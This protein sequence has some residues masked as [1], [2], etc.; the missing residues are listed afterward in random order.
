MRKWNPAFPLVSKNDLASLYST[1]VENS[2]DLLPYLEE[3]RMHLDIGTGGG[4]P[5]I[6][7]AIARPDLNVVV[8]DRSRNKCRFLRHVKFQLKLDNVEVWEEHIGP[9][10]GYS[11]QFDTISVRAVAPPRR[12]WQLGRNLLNPT[13]SVLLHTSSELKAEHVSD[14]RVL[15]S[16]SVSRGWVSAVG[17]LQ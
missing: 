8:N 11:E 14:A 6:S 10:S 9:N 7:L 1:H 2:L 5:G 13:G 16:A 12:A 15:F 17:H 4:F 3:S